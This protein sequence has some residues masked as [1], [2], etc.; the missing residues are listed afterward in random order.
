M[1]INMNN[2]V[3]DTL[4][5]YYHDIKKETDPNLEHLKDIKTSVTFTC[6]V[7]DTFD[8]NYG[9]EAGDDDNIII[10]KQEYF[11]KY[12]SNFIPKETLELFQDY[13]AIVKDIKGQNYGNVLIINFPKNRL[14]YYTGDDYDDLLD[15]GVKY[16]NK[17]IQKMGSL[18][19]YNVEMP[20][21]SAMNRFKYGTTLLNLILNLILL[22]IF[23]LSLILIHSLLL[24][25]TETN[26][27]EF[28]V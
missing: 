8:D 28:G 12:I 18:Q 27:F 2:F 10:M 15:K 7:I 9:K 20:L 22:G 1:T 3:T 25:T 19:H 16:M 11:Y 14:N 26:S 13:N 6:E 24:I 17:V 4:L 5:Y 21:I 23:G